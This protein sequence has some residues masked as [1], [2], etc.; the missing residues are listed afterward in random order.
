MNLDR[1]GAPAIVELS[2]YQVTAVGWSRF[3]GE[4]NRQ[5]TVDTEAAELD[6]PGKGALTRRQF[7]HTRGL[8]YLSGPWSD[9]LC[10]LAKNPVRKPRRVQLCTARY[11]LLTVFAQEGG[12][13]QMVL[14]RLRLG[15]TAVGIGVSTGAVSRGRTP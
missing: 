8:Q 5:R 9:P 7:L 1:A 13:L 15:R 6:R 12:N 2:C 3:D 10:L 11:A 14:G 4:G